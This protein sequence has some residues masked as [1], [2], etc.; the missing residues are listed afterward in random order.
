MARLQILFGLELTIKFIF[1]HRTLINMSRELE[2]LLE[3]KNI[4]LR[5]KDGKNKGSIVSF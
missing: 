5:G 2:L 1:E 4:E 3:L